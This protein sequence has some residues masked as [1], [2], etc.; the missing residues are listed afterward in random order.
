[1]PNAPNNRD[2]SRQGSPCL[3]GQS[4]GKAWQVTVYRVAKSWTQ[5]KGPCMYRH[6]TFFVCGGS[7]PLTVEHGGSAA[8]WLVGTLVVTSVQEQQT[9]SNWERSMAR[10]YIVTLF[11]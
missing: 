8:A 9:G 7:A 10:L 11:T 4:Y 5:L 6:N 3:N 1:M 2:G